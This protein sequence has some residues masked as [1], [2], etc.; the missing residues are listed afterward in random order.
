MRVAAIYDIHAN[1]PALE[2]VLEDI[3]K[4]GADRIIVGGD[5]LPGPM[6]RETLACLRG[7]SIPAQFIT[8]NGDR[9]VLEYLS[10]KEPLEVP[11][12]FREVIRWN[13]R[14]LL[15]EDAQF[16]ATW[17]KT[18]HLQMPGAGNVLFCHA[19]PRNDTDIFTRLTP[20]DRLLPVFADANASLVVC[21][22]THM[23][24][25]RTIGGIRVVNAGSV[26]MPFGEPGAYW[27]LLGPNVKLRRTPYDLE[28]AAA[29][30]RATEYPQA[31]DFASGNVLNPPTE[32]QIL[33]AYSRAE[34]K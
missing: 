7:L 31:E 4:A 8:G 5:A 17:P 19:T 21:G 27:L 34:L 16:L 2:A 6:P 29:R 26:G 11:E 28:S 13:A 9:V 3:R 20:E 1:L 22:H 10:G 33:D 30:I 23:Q 18:L 12:Q 15:P 14:Q 24:F 25:D 32:Q